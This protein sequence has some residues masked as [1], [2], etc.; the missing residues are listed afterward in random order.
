[1]A[2]RT[3]GTHSRIN[4]QDAGTES[5]DRATQTWSLDLQLGD[6][7]VE[8]TLTLLQKGD[9]NPASQHTQGPSEKG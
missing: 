3:A 7:A 8:G 4:R 1:M 5:R 2:V 9:P 6:T